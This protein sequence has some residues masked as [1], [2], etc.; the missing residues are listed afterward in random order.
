[1]LTYASTLKSMTSDRG[2]FHMEFD[3]DE[4][5]PPPVQEKIAAEYARHK[6]EEQER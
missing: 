6:Q 2:T 5:A 4:E 3:R 1:M